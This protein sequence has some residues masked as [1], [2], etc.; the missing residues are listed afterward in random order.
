[1]AHYESVAE[2]QVLKKDE[3]KDN[4]NFKNVSII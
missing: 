2:V 3:E 4:N 1:M